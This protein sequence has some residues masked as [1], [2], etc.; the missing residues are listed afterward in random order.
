[1]RAPSPAPGPGDQMGGRAGGHALGT[2][3]QFPWAPVPPPNL[4]GKTRNSLY[5]EEG[6]KEGR[7]GVLLLLTL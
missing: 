4:V 6:K 5:L 1:M 2:T 3:S 7:E